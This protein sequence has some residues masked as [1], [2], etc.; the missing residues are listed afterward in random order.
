MHIHEY[1]IDCEHELKEC[2]DCNIVY[3]K[4]C[5]KEWGRKSVDCISVP[6][7]A[8]WTSGNYLNYKIY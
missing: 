4:K 2:K 6:Y 1:I 7:P 5:G 3:C 8:I